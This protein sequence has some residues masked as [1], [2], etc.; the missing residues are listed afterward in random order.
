MRRGESD[1]LAILSECAGADPHLVRALYDDELSGLPPGTPRDLRTA[2][3]GANSSWRFPAPDPARAQWWF[4]AHTIERVVELVMSS[5]DVDHS[6]RILCLGAPTVAARLAR[7]AKTVVADID[8]DVLAVV[9][10]EADASLTTYQYDVAS[11]L[12]QDLRG[13]FDAVV[14]DPPWYAAET[15][16][17]ARRA[18]SALRPAGILLLSL[19]PLL[20]RPG[21]EEE[22]AGL[23]EWLSPNGASVESLETGA[24]HYLV[25][26]FEE[27]ALR[28]VEGFTGRPWRTGDLLCVRLQRQFSDS[29]ETTAPSLSVRTFSR[30]PAEFRVFL[31]SAATAPERSTISTV[32]GY[33]ANVSRRAHSVQPDIWTSEKAGARVEK[34][35][36]ARIIVE[37]WAAGKG[38]EDTARALES[39]SHV[40]AET[41]AHIVTQYEQALGLWSRYAQGTPR[42][43]PKE[44]AGARSKLLSEWATRPK[45]TVESDGFRIQFQRDRDRILWSASLR[46][47]GNKT[48]L[49]PAERDDQLRQRLTHSIEVMQL[50]LTVAASFG[51]DEDLV[52]AGALAHDIGHTPFGHAGEHA[53]DRLL[54]RVSPELPGFNHY[55]HGVDVV[56][57]LEAPYQSPDAG[58]YPGLNLTPEVAECIFK[59]TYCQ[60]GDRLSHDSLRKQ[61]K[62]TNL[63]DGYCHLEGQAVRL[64][65]KISYLIS[66]IEDGVRLGAVGE[67][68]LLRCRLFHRPPIELSAN[69]SASLLQR[70][71]QQRKNILKVIMEDA[72]LET[73]RRL[74]R[75]SSLADIRSADEYT[76]D[77]SADLKS[78]LD[79]IWRTIQADRLHRH[80]SVVAE[81]MRAAR[82]VGELTLLFSLFPQFIEPEFRAAHERLHELEYMT[83]YTARAGLTLQIQSP[84]LTFLPVDLMIGERYEP[85]QS[86]PVRTASLVMATDFVASLTDTRAKDLHRRY[87]QSGASFG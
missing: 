21:A 5:I 34:I 47:L 25:P 49:F 59:H 69:P 63:P 71:V 41:A 3:G 43:E 60:T 7:C 86:A 67:Q 61:S 4:T 44:I 42:R 56:R 74:A 8:Q 70:V 84:L 28:G 33:S 46:R 27:V 6:A 77:H 72:I 39:L 53:L 50:A 29:D 80:P 17:F 20:T 31:G 36:E 75:R 48:Q 87:I 37:A 24:L 66:D 73:G 18:L 57:W 65:D 62:H 64:A 40:P 58:G 2:D 30:R 78:D 68:H 26:R 1:F 54:R 83:H 12:P 23:L 35:E 45:Q 22:R 11:P 79:E 13:T 19:P 52:Q 14:A 51:L 38:Q 81:N 16:L 10:S 55:E 15:R 32:D 9:E 76:V 85:G 82:T